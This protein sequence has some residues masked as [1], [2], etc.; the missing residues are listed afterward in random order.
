M[1]FSRT[2]SISGSSPLRGLP[3]PVT[4]CFGPG[5]E[6]STLRIRTLTLS[7]LWT[8]LLP[9]SQ[10]LPWAPWVIGPGISNSHV[11]S[12]SLDTPFKLTIPTTFALVPGTTLRAPSVGVVTL[13][14]T[15]C[16]NAALCLSPSSGM[17]GF[18]ISLFP[19]CF[20]LFR[21]AKTSLISSTICKPS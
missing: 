16:A 11:S 8:W 2:N 12:S 15:F 1:S 4:S 19:P 6:I 7:L 10:L 21:V 18:P 5:T 3:P 17:P 9:H 20:P 13:Y 14:S